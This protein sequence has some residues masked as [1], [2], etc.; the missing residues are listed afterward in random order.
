MEDPAVNLV[1]SLKHVCVCVCVCVHLY[2][3]ACMY[4]RAHVYKRTCAY[5]YVGTCHSYDKILSRSGW[6]SAALW[7]CNY[8][9]KWNWWNVNIFSNS[10]YNVHKK[11]PITARVVKLSD[12]LMTSPPANRSASPV[13]TYQSSGFFLTL[14]EGKS[15]LNLPL[16]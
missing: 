10:W 15:Q 16:T 6:Q 14:R 9:K 13:K 4:A 1:L 5:I 11:R 8:R 3:R 7:W 12:W 2:V